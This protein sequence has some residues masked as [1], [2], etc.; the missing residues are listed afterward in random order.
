MELWDNLNCWGCVM[1]LIRQSLN[2]SDLVSKRNAFS[3]LRSVQ[4]VDHGNAHQLT[5]ACVLFCAQRQKEMSSR[6][7]GVQNILWPHPPFVD[8]GNGPQSLFPSPLGLS[9]L[10]FHDRLVMHSVALT[11]SLFIAD[12]E[13]LSPW[14]CVWY[15]TTGVKCTSYYNYRYMKNNTMYSPFQIQIP[16]FQYWKVLLVICT[17]FVSRFHSY[18]LSL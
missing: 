2:I 10:V 9:L 14:K 4:P 3:R 8:R 16:N 12:R 1:S 7:G 17:C 5:G 18:G 6:L 15:G 13:W 11:K